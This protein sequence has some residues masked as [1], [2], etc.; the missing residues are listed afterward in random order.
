M[1]VNISCQKRKKERAEMVTRVIEMLRGQP[2]DQLSFKAP[3]L[4]TASP[5]TTSPTTYTRNKEREKQKRVHNKEGHDEIPNSCIVCGCG[6]R[7]SVRGGGGQRGGGGPDEGVQ[8]G[9]REGGDVPELRDGKGGAM[10]SKECC[11]SVTEIKN[12][13]PVCLCYIIQQ[14]HNGSNQIKSMGIQEGKLLQL[15]TTCQLTNASVSYC[16]KL[17]N[18]PAGS[19]DASIFTNTNAT[20][21]TPQGPLTTTTGGDNIGSKHSPNLAGLVAVTVAV[22][23]CSFPTEIVSAFY[24]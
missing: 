13:E 24:I 1:G 17:L 19:P 7:V 20:S 2:S 15:P 10:P 6:G 21:T 18:I 23:L 9:F 4:K 11:G 3:T 14:T 8:L 22:L 16:P 12:S 5:I